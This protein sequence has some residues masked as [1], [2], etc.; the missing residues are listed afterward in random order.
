MPMPRRLPFALAYVA[1]LAAPSAGGAAESSVR[2]APA[3]P[4]AIR[5]TVTVPSPQ[6]TSLDAADGLMRMDLAEYR[7]EAAEPGG[8]ALPSRVITVAVPP[9]G[10]VRLRAAATSL[11]TSD[12]LLLAPLPAP[13]AEPAAAPVLRRDLAAYGAAGSLE[14]AGARLLG[15]G[16]M[17]N[18]RVARIA[19]EPAAY[20]PAARRL[21]LA[22]RVD[23]EVQVEPMGRLGPP[24]EEVDHFETV[25][26][27]ALLNYEQG[28]AWRRPSTRDLAEA[29]RRMGVAPTAANG[30]ADPPDSSVFVGRTWV[31]FAIDRAGFYSVNYSRLRTTALFGNDSCATDS[32]RLF[33]WPG[34][35]VLP[36]ANYCDT[37]DYRE[38]ALGLIDARGDGRF[39]DNNDLFYFFAQGASGWADEYEPGMPD[40]VYINH[41]YETRN[42]YYLTIATPEAPVGGTPRR[43]ATRSA[44]PTGAGTPVTTV[45][46][47]VHLEQDLEFWPDASSTISTLFWEKWF[48]RSMGSG[49]FFNVDFDLPHAD[50]AQPARIRLRQ[51]GL[52]DNFISLGCPSSMN[53]P[54]H[55][56]DATI[57]GVP[58]G[59]R[60]WRGSTDR[61]GGAL[62]IDTTGFLLRTTSPNLIALSVPTLS[63]SQSPQCPQRIDRSALA[64]VDVFYE[65]RLAPDADRLAFRS[66]A[67]AGTFRYDVGPF[68]TPTPP[69]LFDVTDPLQPVELVGGSY[70]AAT[71]AFEDAQA[72]RR[73][74][75]VMPDSVISRGIL[76]AA[77]IADAAFTSLDNLRSPARSADYVLIYYDGFKTAADSLVEWRRSSLPVLDGRTTHEAVAIPVSAIHDQFSGGRT[78]P[79]AIRNFLRSA[80]FNWSRRPTFVT[81]LGD[82]SY[83]YKNLTGRAPAGQ[84]GTLVTTYDNLFDNSF[85]VQRMYASDD[86]M[87]N[88]NDAGLLIP[89]YLGGRL[90]ANDAAT[91]LAVVRDK[92]LRYE[93]SAPFGEY[94]NRFM[95]IA[96]DDTQGDRCDGLGWTHVFQTAFLDTASIA[97]HIDRAY[98]YLHTYPSGPGGTRPGARAAIKDHINSGVAVFNY[99]GHGSPFKISDESVFIDSDAGTLTNGPRMPLFVAASCDVGKFNDPT[100]QSLGERLVMTGTGGAVGV[101]SATELAFS[102]DN[103]ILNLYLYQQFFRR[104]DLLVRGDTLRGTGQYHVPVSAALLAAKERAG[105]SVTNN[106]KYQLMGD[107]GM[108]LNLPRLWTEITLEDAAGAPVTSL[109]RGQTITYRGRVLDQPGGALVPYSGVA[110]LL[111]EDSRPVEVTS[112]ASGC[113]FG[114][115]SFFFTAG[116]MFKGDASTENGIFEGRF[117]VPLDAVAG[118]AGRVRAYIR[119][120]PL[121]GT[122]DT[123]GVG[124]LRAPVVAGAAPAGDNEGPRINLSF[125]GGAVSVRPDATLQIDLF[126]ESGI[127]TTGHALQNSIVVTLDDNTTNRTDV[128]ASF[129]YAADSYQSGTAT[130]QLPDLAP[131]PH[132][133]R[134]SA[135]DNLATGITASQHRSSA[136]LDFEVVDVP[137]L[138]VAR[139][140]LFPTPASSTGPAP[141]GVFVVDAPGDSVNTLIR[142]YTVSGRLVRTLRQFGGLGQVQIPWDGRDA[143]GAPLANGTY[144]YKVHVSVRDADGSSSA[145]QRAIAEGRFIILNR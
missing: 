80:F 101:I 94:R 67:G 129:R 63:S 68:V 23:V 29:A 26:Q 44:T 82:A 35:P 103:A 107:S 49:G 58:I 81:F 85:I 5:F 61:R 34:L 1:L 60:G 59:R 45:S 145:R 92:I 112:N 33:T 71:L 90:P 89:D 28:L 141:G 18:Q 78:D 143:E 39:S 15:V 21:T 99:V 126:D 2:L 77:Q 114:P 108:R 9:L 46:D 22:R 72:D 121:S 66:P 31:R 32:L 115:A 138:N 144:L 13:G 132:R 104:G 41:P 97:S 100:V 128:T 38:V 42:F 122:A 25:Y 51:W 106:S 79:G 10:E 73:R 105:S 65:R 69:R 118:D 125:V 43:I 55:L 75:A 86:W 19:I 52:T 137:P 57:N 74:Y 83:D 27:G 111:I 119:G 36:E 93:R 7:L 134:V 110:S 117:V 91:A 84:P 102:G 16:W 124:D 76:P 127:M 120:R 3:T 50:L 11:E 109:Q 123:D 64:W 56:L 62:T 139:T 95:L 4:G 48:W 17:R 6:L 135:A 14:P 40:T 87:L 12:G 88:I 54:D 70:A 30:I 96:D 130:F 133:V 113:G 131:G 20:A 8:P 24:A 98:V 142:V 37:C 47:R 53:P 140:Y 116:P 136:T